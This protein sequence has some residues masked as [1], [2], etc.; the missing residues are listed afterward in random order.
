MQAITTF[1]D[2]LVSVIKTITVMD[3]LDV[4]IVSYIVY[5][6]FILVRETRAAQLLK[7]VIVF[8]VAY[9]LASQLGLESLKFLLNAILQFGVVTLVVVFQP[10]IRRALEKVGR[11]KLR[12]LRFFSSGS[13]VDD[14]T[15][16]K[17]EKAIVVVCDAADI[18]SG[19]KTGALIVIERKTKLGD[20]I[21]TGTVV[22]AE[23]SVELF[24]NL[25]FVN[26]PLH[27]GAVVMRDGRV[28]A[29]GCFLPLSQ[30]FEISKELG[31]R[32]RAALGVSENSDAVVV[33]VSEETGLISVACDGHLHRGIERDYLQRLL[34]NELLPQAPAAEQKKR[35]F[36][37]GRREH[38]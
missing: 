19:K 1:F 24:G 18:L 15:R 8:L 9:V 30:N 4:A 3:V 13:T 2:S 7:G 36:P 22:D 31:T 26:T 12:S 38:R 37:F 20:I 23:P 33:V 32:H 28:C 6:A 17:V 10:E 35:R 21:S 27:D 25:F 5:V 29:A 16:R 11:T 14:A 34:S